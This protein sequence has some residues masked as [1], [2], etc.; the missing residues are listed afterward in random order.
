MREVHDVEG[1]RAALESK[2]S[3]SEVLFRNIDLRG[4]ATDLLGRASE[5]PMLLGCTL[6]PSDEAEL[7]RKGAVVFPSLSD[8]PYEAYRAELYTPEELFEAYDGQACSYCDCLDARV[9]QHWLKTGRAAPKSPKEALARR[10]HDL[11]ITE[12]LERL[13]GDSRKVVAIMGGHSMLRGEGSYATVAK[14]SRVLAQKGYLMASGGGPGAMEA[15][16]LGVWFADYEES[17]LDEAICILSEAPKYNH[18]DWLVRAFDVRKK[19][20]NANPKASLGVPTWFYGHEPPNAFASHIAKYFENSIREE[21]LVTL[22][23]GGV[24]FAPGMAGTVQEVFQ[25]AAQNHYGTVASREGAGLISPMVLFGREYWTEKLPVIPLLEK[26][27]AGR[28]YEKMI[29]VEDD[30]EAVVRFIEEH[31]P[32]D[33]TSGWSFCGAHC[34][35]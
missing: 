3:L 14:M 20:P 31:P 35:E 25:D 7:V 23:T 2:S 29:S 33:V 32:I 30:P 22:A 18:R 34:S 28:D 16:H 17:D 19:F 12:A 26:L 13:L 15:T 4:N 8:I 10:L 27:S 6:E 21:G 9:Y 5:G 24:I 11:S 1:A